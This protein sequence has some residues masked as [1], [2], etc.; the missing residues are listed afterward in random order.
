[1]KEMHNGCIRH[2]HAC[3]S[4]TK[5]CHPVRVISMLLSLQRG[6]SHGGVNTWEPD[7]GNFIWRLPNP[8]LWLPLSCVLAPDAL[9]AISI[10]DGNDDIRVFTEGD[11]A[12]LGLAV[13]GLYGPHQWKY[14]VLPR[15]R[16]SRSELSAYWNVLNAYV[17]RSCEIGANRRRVSRHTASNH[18][19][20]MRVS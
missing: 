16:T 2:L 13:G 17:L 20:P 18:G 5:E 11:F 10:Y 12:Y 6:D 19:R 1:M 14:D 15:T 7:L 3:S 9:A 4:T 8:T